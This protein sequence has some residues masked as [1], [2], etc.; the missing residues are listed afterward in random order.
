[1]A[2]C[3]AGFDGDSPDTIK[4]MARRLHEAGVDVPFLSILTPFR[5]SD[6]YQKME[7]DNRLLAERGW[8]FYNGY[9]VTFRPRNMSPEEL[10]SAHRQL[11]RE[12]FSIK[13]SFLRVLRSLGYL[14]PGA[15]LM[16][17]F[18]N[19]YYCLKRL[20]GNEPVCFEEGK[21]FGP[22]EDWAQAN[23]LKTARQSPVL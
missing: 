19:A 8:E 22:D 11:W 6:A 18:M 1:M 13:Y 5:G 2:G 16:C 10:L 4:A 7:A 23:H 21:Y 14:R 17:L 9:N 12:A 3:I 20:R 15:F